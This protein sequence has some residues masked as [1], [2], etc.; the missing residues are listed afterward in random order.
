MLRTLGA[1]RKLCRRGSSKPFLSRLSLPRRR[2]AC[3]WRL[4]RFRILCRLLAQLCPWLI[5]LTAGV[6]SINLELANLPLKCGG[7]V[8]SGLINA[9]YQ[10]QF[11]AIQGFKENGSINNFLGAL[12]FFVGSSSG[13]TTLTEAMRISSGGHV[14]IGTTSPVS[15]L[16]VK[17]QLTDTGSIDLTNSIAFDS[18]QTASGGTG[19][20]TPTKSVINI[21]VSGPYTLVSGA[22]RNL[23]CIRICNMSGSAPTIVGYY[24]SIS[25]NSYTFVDAIKD[26]NGN[27]DLAMPAM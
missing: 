1:E 27:W 6:H 15:P 20:L 18:V 3:R 11:S 2:L 12:R 4:V 24:H 13:S 9:S 8:F 22:M 21:T 14:G 17:G 7:I 16:T 25:L 19:N 26:I 5:E 10:N 23:S